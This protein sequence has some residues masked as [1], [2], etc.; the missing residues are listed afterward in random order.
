MFTV[1]APNNFDG[2]KF[3]TKYNLG[4]FDFHITNGILHSPIKLT[5]H[6]L[7]DCVQITD[8]IE[9]GE[10]IELRKNNTWKIEENLFLGITQDEFLDWCSSNLMTDNEID[11]TNLP[12]KVQANLKAQNFFVRNMGCMLITIR[13]KSIPGALK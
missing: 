13:D 2:E 11:K 10:R 4:M 7:L 3:R 9:K 5:P 6:D 8:E 12:S 1:P